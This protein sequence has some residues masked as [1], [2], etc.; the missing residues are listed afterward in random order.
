MRLQEQR[1]ERSSRVEL[2]KKE[3][4]KNIEQ[5]FGAKHPIIGGVHFSPLPG[6]KEFDS[7]ER[8]YDQALYDTKALERG[9]AHGVIFENNYDI[10]HKIT[11]VGEQTEQAM[12]QLIKQLKQNTSLPIGISVLFN[13]YK[14]ALRIAKE[15]G[16]SF[17]RVPVFVDHVKTSYGEVIGNPEDVIAYR[18]EIGADNVLLFTDI[19]VKHSEILN[20]E[21]IQQSAR[22]A[23]TAGSDGL[24]ITGKWTG[25]APDIGELK[26]VRKVVGDFPIILGSGVSG[27]N[28][29]SLFQTA[30]GAIVSTSLKEGNEKEGEVNVKGYE[31]RISEERVKNLTEA[32]N[33]SQ[34]LLFLC[35]GNVG[36]SPAAEAYFNFKARMAKNGRRAI[37]AGVIDVRK[38]YDHPTPA[39]VQSLHEVGIPMSFDKKVKLVNKRMIRK[40][41][42]VVVFC[43]KEDIPKDLLKHFESKMTFRYVDD[44]SG[45]WDIQT[46]RQVRDSVI[47]TINEFL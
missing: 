1:S 37:S 26:R 3:K 44:P 16:A 10:P 8:V 32:V 15:V 13:D 28:I 30:D 34:D 12:I 35:K 38:Q 6:Y 7:L 36:R 21:T 20:S 14:T 4:M 2:H 46:A 41:D 25:D 11:D 29:S 42:T 31:Q 5:L 9:G 43:S 23:V 18:R 27:E 39:I 24:I 40:A 22:N 19:H 45:I 47:Q 33:P 17:I